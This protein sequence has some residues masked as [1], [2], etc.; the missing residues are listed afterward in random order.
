V[1]RDSPLYGRVGPA[2]FQHKDDKTD[3]PSPQLPAERYGLLMIFRVF[4]R[5]SYAL[6]MAADRQ[7][8]VLDIVT[9]P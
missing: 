1:T 8:N 6:I 9:N 7:V 2:G 3:L 5:A 4:E